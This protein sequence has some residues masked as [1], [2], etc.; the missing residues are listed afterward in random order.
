MK[1]L[2]ISLQFLL[3]ASLLK[4]HGHVLPT[5]FAME[6]DFITGLD[7]P[8]DLK[9]APDGRIFITEKNGNVRIVENGV[10]LPQP[11]YSVTTQVPNERGLDGIILDPNFDANG[12]VYLY[13]TL[14]FENKNKVARVTSGGNTAIPGSEIELIRFDN[15]W[16]S[17]HNGAGMA[18]DTDGKLIIGTGDGTGFTSSQDMNNSLGKIL[19][20]NTDGSIPTDNPFYNT[21]TG[22]YRAIAAYGARNPYTMA[23]SKL[24]GRIFFNDVGNN[25]YEEVNEFLMGK[26]YGWHLVE[27]PLGASTPP[28][29]NYKDPIHAYDHT[30]G[31]AIVGATFYEPDINLFPTEYYGKYFFVEYCEGKVLYMDPDTYTVTEFGSGLDDGY[32]NIEASHDGYLYLINVTYGKLSRISFQGASSPPLISIQPQDQ[33]VP[34][35]ENVFFSVEATGDT[36]SYDW[37]AN[38]N[39]IQSTALNSTLLSNV[40]LG[41]NQTQV[42]AVINNPHGSMVSDTAVLTVVTGS[43][44]AIQFQNIPATYAGGDS[45]YF[46]A[47]VSDPDQQAVPDA[48]LTWKIDFHH[49]LHAHPALSPVSGSSS[50]VYYV[51]TYGEVDTNVFYRIFCTAI[52]SSGL[53]TESYVDVQPEK[54]TMV[55]NSVPNGVQISIDGTEEMTSYPLRSVKNLNRTLEIPNYAIVGDSLYEF[56]QWD[57]AQTD[58]TRTFSAQNGTHTVEYAPLNEYIQGMPAFGN[59]Q[60]FT[61]TAA[62]QVYYNTLTVSQI[63]ENWDIKNPYPWD[64]P[65]FPDDYWSARW[66][67]S[68]LAPVSDLYTFYLFHD[69]RVS[70]TIGDT[71]LLDRVLSA[72]DLQEDTVQLWLNAGDSLPLILDYDHHNYLARV[73]LDWSYSIVPRRVVEFTQPEIELPTVDTFSVKDGIVLFP[74]PSDA[75]TAYL[76]FKLQTFDQRPINVRVFDNLGRLWTTMDDTVKSA[77][78]P[79]SI[80]KLPPGFYYFWITAGEEKI[81]LKYIKR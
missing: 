50:G 47:T 40:Q 3:F 78:I 62:N 4:A 19:R 70:L 67:G 30:F 13:Y 55:F 27:G 76:Y 44:P 51:E 32:N 71:L 65:P 7:K 56:L 58:L 21:Q 54:V 79:I 6:E 23:A 53:S 80:A 43:R 25:D 26:N 66:E 18:F 9:I 63:K 10:L 36:L 57:D 41:D 28:D 75:E 68:I 1:Y 49:D 2:L 12:Y 15:M 24:S 11:F 38:G 37:Y 61:D 14:P 5:G 16:A 33:T 20:I 52:D 60:V 35:G 48:D 81:V 17:W 29:N 72:T 74:N 69:G 73:E 34:V 22:V 39:L 64:N 77:V 31:C 59:L 45:I 46:A 42:Y 8:T